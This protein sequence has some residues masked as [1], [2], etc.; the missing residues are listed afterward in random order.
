MNSLHNKNLR[1]PSNL[2][3]SIKVYLKCREFLQMDERLQSR[4]FS[5]IT[6]TEQRTSLMKLTLSAVLNIKILSGY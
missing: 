3:V 4:G 2:F 6:D 5:T 1:F